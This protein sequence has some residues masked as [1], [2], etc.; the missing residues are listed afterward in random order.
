MISEIDKNKFWSHSPSFK[1]TRVDGEIS[2]YSDNAGGVG[3]INTF[4]H[5][6]FIATKPEETDLQAVRDASA[7]LT[8]VTVQKAEKKAKKAKEDLF[9]KYPHAIRG[10]AFFDTTEKVEKVKIRCTVCGNEERA[11]RKTDLFQTKRC[12]KCQAKAK[13]DRAEKEKLARQVIKEVN[14]GTITLPQLEEKCAT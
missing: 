13:A 9:E 1:R 14:A 10:S 7:P 2:I 5:R 3:Y 4:S 12:E 11:V 6:Y 8:G